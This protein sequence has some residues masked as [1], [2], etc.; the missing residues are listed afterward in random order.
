MSVLKQQIRRWAATGAAVGLAGLGCVAMAQAPNEGDGP[1]VGDHLKGIDSKQYRVDQN[2]RD[3]AEITF[4]VD[5]DVEHFVRYSNGNYVKWRKKVRFDGKARL[6]YV[7]GG[8]IYTTGAL[9][10]MADLPPFA[11]AQYMAEG[12]QACEKETDPVKMGQCTAAATAAGE[13]KAKRCRETPV[14]SREAQGCGGGSSAAP[15]GMFDVLGPTRDADRYDETPEGDLR[16][17]EAITCIGRTKVNGRGEGLDR[18]L[19]DQVY[20]LSI[21]G[22]YE[23]ADPTKTGTT[24]GCSAGATINVK[25]GEVRLFLRPSPRNIM[26]KTIYSDHRGTARAPFPTFEG[27]EGLR[28]GIAIDLVIPPGSKTFS[29]AWRPPTKPISSPDDPGVTHRVQTVVNYA[30]VGE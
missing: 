28:D 16:A 30:F 1:K 8:G 15:H 27:L 26:T 24:Q 22:D 19:A 23:T 25:T 5:A 7:Y 21:T 9:D 20:T 18:S 29:G 14:A 13:A 3:F 17:W 4:S 11:E 12:W 6:K 2:K 10:D